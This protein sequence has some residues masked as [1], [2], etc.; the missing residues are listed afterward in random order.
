LRDSML[1]VSGK[2]NLQAGGPGVRLPLNK[3]IAN[4]QYKGVWTATPNPGQ[5][6]RRT[7]FVFLKR[8]N[9]P[10]LLE[11]F[12]SP[13]TM[14][15]CGRRSV[16]VHAGQALTLLNGE[17]SDAQ[18]TAFAHRLLGKHGA[19]NFRSLIRGAYQ[20]ALTRQPKSVELQLAERFLVEQQRNDAGKKDEK[21]VRSLSDLCLVL[22]NLDEFLYVD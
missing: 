17:F 15:S 19:A 7:V 6:V 10:P 3:E 13:S 12:D 16:S 9:R 5:H 22:F 18:A 14:Q 20:L 11:S 8:N 4:L 2:L 1:A 21:L